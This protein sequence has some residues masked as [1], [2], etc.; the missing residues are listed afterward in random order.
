MN[1][2][3]K[4][5]KGFFY[6]FSSLKEAWSLKGRHSCVRALL[7]WACRIKVEILKN[8]ISITRGCQTCVSSGFFFFSLK[9]H[10]LQRWQKNTGLVLGGHPPQKPKV[11][12]GMQGMYLLQLLKRKECI[13]FSLVADFHPLIQVSE[14]D[15]LCCSILSK[16]I[17]SRHSRR[18]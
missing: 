1:S 11:K 6:P 14:K 18:E 9:L 12:C 13:F 4:N 7:C 10:D 3:D 17:T 2:R 15:D 8:V 5:Y 16:E